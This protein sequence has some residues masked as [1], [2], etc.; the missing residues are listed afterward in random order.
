M[1]SGVFPRAEYFLFEANPENTEALR[2]SGERFFTAALSW[3]DG[4]PAQFFVPRAAISATGASLYRERTPHYQGNSARAIDVTTRRLDSIV[5]ES[6]LPAPDLIKLDVQ[7]AE[8]DVMK[9]SGALLDRCSAI[10]A[11]VSLLPGN[12]GAPLAT[13][14][15]VGFRE[16][17]FCCVDVCKIRRTRGGTVSQFDFLFAKGELYDRY[18]RVADVLPLKPSP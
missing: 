1:A 6:G 16:Y 8:L 17:G 18:I 14:I 7:G 3:Q 5:R 4:V 12:E 10:I 11:E 9:G 13:D 15:F 2:K